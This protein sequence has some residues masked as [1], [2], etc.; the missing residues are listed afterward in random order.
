MDRSSIIIKN[1]T[2][3][4]LKKTG[5]K[6]QTYDDVINELIDLKIS[7]KLSLRESSV[8]SLQS[9]ESSIQ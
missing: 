5:R 8:E 9:S 4:K 7:R 2:R 3:Q 6:D 1:T